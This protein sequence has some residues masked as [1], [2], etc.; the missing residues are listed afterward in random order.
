[1]QWLPEVQYV[2][3]TVLKTINKSPKYE[4]IEMIY[5]LFNFCSINSWLNYTML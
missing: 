1:M 5:T 3:S 4:K 2:T